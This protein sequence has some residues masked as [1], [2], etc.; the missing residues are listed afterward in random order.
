MMIVFLVLLP[1]VVCLVAAWLMSRG[2]GTSDAAGNGQE[3]SIYGWHMPPAA[4]R[5]LAEPAGPTALAVLFALVSLPIVALSLD[6]VYA[7]AGVYLGQDQVGRLP[8]TDLG[9]WTAA[10]GA[11]L[12]AAVFSGT[13]G[14]LLVRRHAKL[15]GLLTLLLAWQVGIATLPLAPALLHQD[16]G[17]VYFCLDGCS[18]AIESSDP[19]TALQAA[20]TPWAVQLSPLFAPVP[21]VT[22]A[23]GVIAWTR[24][25][26]RF[27][28][29][30]ES[31]T[32]TGR[33]AASRERA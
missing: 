16:V 17:F 19:A 15:G 12:A 29:N 25:L 6:G 13:I 30:R 14:G 27:S 7:P 33:E 28:V 31:R 21:F 1:A 5:L 3:W 24:L 4:Q 32:P 9:R 22:L 26:R 8:L 23:V 2:S 10:A 20:V 11:V 18:A